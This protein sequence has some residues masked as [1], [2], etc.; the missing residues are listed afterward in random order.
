VHEI[1][2]NVHKPAALDLARAR[3]YI[4]PV[5]NNNGTTAATALLP[6]LLLLTARIAV[7]PVRSV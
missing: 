7:G 3:A 6:G 5:M 4:A 2:Q 1:V